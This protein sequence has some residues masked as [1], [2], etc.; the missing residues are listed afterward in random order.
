LEVGIRKK[1]VRK[2]EKIEVDTHFGID[3]MDL[4]RK[5]RLKEF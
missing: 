3:R 1:E 2:W 4:W 5:N